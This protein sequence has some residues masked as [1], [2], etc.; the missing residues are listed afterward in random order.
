MHIF[1]K[2]RYFYEPESECFMDRLIE[3]EPYLSFR[4]CEICHKT[5]KHRGGLSFGDIGG[6]YETL[7]D[8]K[9]KVV[10]ELINSGELK[11]FAKDTNGK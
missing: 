10:E 5:Q 3:S 9:S 1:H 11:F 4:R 7:S 2:W 8:R 6:Y